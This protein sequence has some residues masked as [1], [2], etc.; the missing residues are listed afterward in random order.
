[1]RW[2]GDVN[3]RMRCRAG[4]L[5]VVL[6]LALPAMALAADLVGRPQTGP[7]APSEP[8]GPSLTS[9]FLRL[10]LACLAIVALLYGGSRLLRRLPLSRFLPGGDGPIRIEGRTLLGP[11]E[12]LCLVRVG[13]RTI[14]IGVTAGRIM[15]LHAWPEAELAAERGGRREV[16]ELERGAELPVQLRSLHAR[17]G[18][19]SR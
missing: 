11:K 16:A 17:L 13:A 4:V 19:R 8:A 7:G 3:A 15:P 18:A 9:S 12:Y 6:L 2:G 1:M 5:L 14:L 10:G